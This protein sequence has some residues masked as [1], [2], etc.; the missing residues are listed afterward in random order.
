MT[1]EQKNAVLDAVDVN[2]AKLK[3]K[4]AKAFGILVSTLSTIIN[5]REKIEGRLT[6]GRNEKNRRHRAA[7]FLQV[8]KADY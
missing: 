2:S 4:T 7:E 6:D 8:E 1:L 5:D 3:I